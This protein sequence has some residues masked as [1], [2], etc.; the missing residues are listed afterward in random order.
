MIM[1]LQIL[2]SS[3]LFFSLFLLYL[4]Y[5]MSLQLSAVTSRA[6]NL[7]ALASKLQTK[8][9]V[10]ETAAVSSNSAGSNDLILA[11]CLF[12]LSA[13]CIIALNK[14]LSGGSVEIL[15][16]NSGTGLIGT[17]RGSSYNTV[18]SEVSEKSARVDVKP[19]VEIINNS[20]EVGGPALDTQSGTLGVELQGDISKQ[21]SDLL[22]F[23]K[24]IQEGVLGSMVDLETLKLGLLNATPDSAG[25]LYG[26][27]Y[28]ALD[29]LE[30]QIRKVIDSNI[31]LTKA[32]AAGQ[33]ETN[34]HTSFCVDEFN[35]AVSES[36]LELRTGIINHLQSLMRSNDLA[37]PSITSRLDVLAAQLQEIQTRLDILAANGTIADAA[38]VVG[39]AA[40]TL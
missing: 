31:S 37:A 23:A 15:S 34:A 38:A 19:E 39:D 11:A 29:R 32:V 20:A 18:I 25:V 10:L 8:L 24:D 36:F 27:V 16:S 3:F 40:A 13:V 4:N 22:G 21:L 12:L 33:S 30:A 2:F 9:G 5:Q 6:E 14:S 28:W 1:I 26:N 17:N 7:E 35:Q